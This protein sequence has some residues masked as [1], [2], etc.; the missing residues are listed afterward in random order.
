MPKKKLPHGWMDPLCRQAYGREV[1]RYTKPQ[2]AEV[3]VHLGRSFLGVAEI[4]RELGGQAFAI[5]TWG[6]DYYPRITNRQ[7]LFEQTMKEWGVS[8]CVTCIRQDAVQVARAWPKEQPLDVVYLDIHF[9]LVGLGKDIDAWWPL[10]RE[11]GVLLG[12][13]ALSVNVRRVLHARFL[14]HSVIGSP[15]CG[16]WKVVKEPGARREQDQE[17]KLPK[18]NIHL[19]KANRLIRAGDAV[20]YKEEVAKIKGGHVVE[21]GCHL[22]GSLRHVG[23]I[24]RANKTALHAV[25]PWNVEYGFIKGDRFEQFLANMKEEGLADFI[26]PLRTMSH[27]AA[28]RFADESIDLVFIDGC[29]ALAWVLLDIDSWWPK[30]KQGGVLLGHDWDWGDVK[31]A[32]GLR[33][34]SWTEPAGANM[35]KIIKGRDEYITYANSG[36]PLYPHG[37]PEL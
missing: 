37:T 12:D 9:D 10:V 3:G 20:V 4:C 8:D 6:D 11:G 21:V 34:K 1:R 26:I 30:L 35:F 17:V 25:D 28:E 7:S 18:P 15:R 36:R 23:P 22:G 5:D 13:S 33:F 27:L 16:L 2:I 29:H 19:Q 24:C 31:Q 14:E 32:V